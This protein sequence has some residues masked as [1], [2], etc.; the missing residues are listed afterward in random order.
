M[1]TIENDQCSLYRYFNKIVKGPEISFQSPALGKK[2]VRNI[3][4]TAH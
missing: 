2:R 3:C 1:S 4:H